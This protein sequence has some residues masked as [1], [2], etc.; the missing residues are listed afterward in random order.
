MTKTSSAFSLV[1]ISGAT[2]TGA[3][4]ATRSGLRCTSPGTSEV[5]NHSASRGEKNYRSRRFD[6]EKGTEEIGLLFWA[7]I[8]CG[9]SKGFDTAEYLISSKGISFLWDLSSAKN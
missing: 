6:K 7:S 5:F 2:V 4:L 3:P 8:R 1:T 9:A